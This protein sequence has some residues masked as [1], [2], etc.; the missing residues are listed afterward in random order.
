MLGIGRKKKDDLAAEL[1]AAHIDVEKA[2]REA[3][4]LR[5]EVQAV[6]IQLR[7]WHEQCRSMEN[8]LRITQQL[9][10][11]ALDTMR[12]I[13]ETPPDFENEL[14]QV[15]AM[16]ESQPPI[17]SLI[18]AVALSSSSDVQAIRRLFP[19]I[20]K[21]LNQIKPPAQ[22]ISDASGERTPIRG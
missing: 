11:G 14:T 15:K 2:K 8:Q 4:R 7:F 6:Q 18:M 12:S 3:D 17:E 1:R 13:K 19:E 16:L 20:G 5:V 10:M 21:A 9:Y 22:R